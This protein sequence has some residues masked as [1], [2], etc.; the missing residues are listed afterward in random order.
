M[1]QKRKDDSKLR[2]SFGRCLLIDPDFFR[3]FYDDFL[4]SHEEIPPFFKNT[5]FKKQASLLRDAVSYC[6]MFSEGSPFAESV[7]GRLRTLHSRTKL[8]VHPK[9]Y[10]YWQSTLIL[11]ISKTD[12]EFN[13]KLESEWHKV[14]QKTVDLMTAGY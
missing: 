7:L 1:V 14:L 5:D 12:P 9:Y 13:P 8:N 10:K 6:I 2:Q 4:S 11:R 3:H